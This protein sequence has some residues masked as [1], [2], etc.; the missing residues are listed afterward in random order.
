LPERSQGLVYLHMTS[1]FVFASNVI[2]AKKH[3]LAQIAFNETSAPEP[4]EFK[5]LL[6]Y[7]KSGS[8]RF[9][10]D[11]F[12]DYLKLGDSQAEGRIE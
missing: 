11:K 4:A 2:G 8:P 5:D 6:F 10:A 3:Y 1:H 7:E 9:L 12:N